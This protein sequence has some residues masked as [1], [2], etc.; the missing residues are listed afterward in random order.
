MSERL[1]DSP[2]CIVADGSDP[3]IQMQHLMKLMGQESGENFHPVLEINPGHSII[4]KMGSVEKDIT[5]FTRRLNSI[6][7][8]AL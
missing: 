1:T 2:S 5:A 8:K 3:T 6:M 7:A 4:K